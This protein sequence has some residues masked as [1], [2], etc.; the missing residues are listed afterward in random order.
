[1][2]LHSKK[3]PW[4]CEHLC[5]C[6]HVKPSWHVRQLSGECQNVT[7]LLT[8]WF[9]SIR[10]PTSIEKKSGW[11][12]LPSPTIVG[13][14]Q[15][16]KAEDE[17]KRWWRTMDGSDSKVAR[18]RYSSDGD[19]SS[20]PSYI[21]TWWFRNTS[22]DATVHWEDGSTLKPLHTLPLNRPL[23]SHVTRKLLDYAMKGA[24]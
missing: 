16:S 1:M 9:Q 13:G 12:L 19:V 11:T 7:S 4:G 20:L 14:N 21:G 23:N 24:R 18:A 22:E 17:Y 15:T 3:N 6:T 2:L 10:M 5:G 8:H